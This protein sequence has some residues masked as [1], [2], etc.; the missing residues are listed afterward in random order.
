MLNKNF[1]KVKKG[2]FIVID[3]GDG[4]GKSTVINHLKS[5]LSENEN[6]F[7]REPGGSDFA[8]KIRELMLSDDAKM[9]SN[10]T[11][12]GLIWASRADHVEKTVAPALLGGKN[13]ISDRFDSSTYAYQIFAQEG[14]DLKDLF[15][16]IREKFL[17]YTKPDLY[18]YLDVDVEV[19]IERTNRRNSQKQNHFDHNKNEFRQKVKD[20]FIEFTSL[21]PSRIVDANKT[22]DFVKKE[23][24]DIVLDLINNHK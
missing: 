17:G 15:F 9:V 22:I 21:V 20:G 12:F 8:Q 1:Q 11:H 5:I 24:M 4:S 19:G 23:C 2:K 16:D 18:I 10:R 6:V 3:G 7:T 13:V 14:N